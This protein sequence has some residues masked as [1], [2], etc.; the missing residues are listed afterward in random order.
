M[1]N[2]VRPRAPR[3]PAR[4]VDRAQEHVGALLGHARY[5]TNSVRQ[6]GCSS[7]RVYEWREDAN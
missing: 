4:A 6:S 5:V 3:R 7:G 2:E 1:A